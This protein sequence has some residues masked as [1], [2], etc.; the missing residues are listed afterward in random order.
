[1]AKRTYAEKIAA[2]TPE[3]LEAFKRQRQAQ[4]ARHREKHREAIKAKKAAISPE[5]RE[6]RRAHARAY[7][8]AQIAAM[9]PDQLKAFRDKEKVLSKTYYREN[10]KTL[11]QYYRVRSEALGGAQHIKPTDPDEG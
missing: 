6:K 8:R 1:M 9:T 10:K 11:Q 7:Y 5:D 3:R 2:M 4:G